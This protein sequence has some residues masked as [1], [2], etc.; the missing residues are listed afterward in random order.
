[1]QRLGWRFPWASSY[2]NNFNFD[3]HVS[4]TKDDL[5]KGSIHYNFAVIDDPKYIW[6]ELPGLSVAGRGP[7]L[8]FAMAYNSFDATYA[9]PVGFGWRHSYDMQLGPVRSGS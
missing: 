5:A 2:G 7:G 8:H 1:M 4:F 3:Y 9:G 6:D